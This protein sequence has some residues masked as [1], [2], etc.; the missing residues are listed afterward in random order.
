[1]NNIP[2]EEVRSFKYLGLTFTQNLRWNN[3]VDTVVTKARKKIS[4]MMPLKFKISRNSL[5]IMYKSFVV[6]VLEYGIIV[7]GGTYDTDI[8]KLEKIHVDAMRLITG[9]TARSN[10]AELYK[11]TAFLSIR[12]RI[13]NLTLTML[14]KTK[15]N[16]SPGYLTTL[17]PNSNQEANRY[18]LRN[19]HNL[20]LPFSR[21]E[22]FKRSFFPR[23]TRLWNALSLTIRDSRSLSIF[24][25]NLSNK[26]KPCNVLY[27]Y[28]ERWPAVHHARIRIGCSKLNADLCYRLHVKDSPACSCGHHIEDP[29]HFFMACNNF[30]V[31][32]QKLFASVVPL[33]QV[34]LEILLKGSTTLNFVDNCTVFQS[35]H[36]FIKETKRFSQ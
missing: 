13:D 24:K 28:G 35:V 9:A 30:Q 12:D 18:N 19:N 31:A 27:Y 17:L 29:Y 15:N 6:P 32:R 4:A 7:W 3:H 11:E 5:E 16:L 34:T 21:L 10:I 8:I 33:T 22:T 2:I 25:A 26:T 20:R 1:M 14:Y 23:A 36:S